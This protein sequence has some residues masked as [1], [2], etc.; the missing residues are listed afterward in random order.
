[1]GS[2]IREIHLLYSLNGI[3]WNVRTL[4]VLSSGDVYDGIWS[5]FIPLDGSTPES[6]SFIVQAV[7][8]AGNVAYAAN[9]G[10]SYSGAESVTYLPLVIKND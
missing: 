1:M 7:D 6:L 8:Q 2:G 10:Q 3:D 5:G 9:K 4:W